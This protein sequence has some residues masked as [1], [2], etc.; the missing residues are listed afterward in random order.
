LPETKQGVGSK[1]PTDIARSQARCRGFLC[2][3]VGWRPPATPAEPP[4]RGPL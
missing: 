2:V 4:V 1:D 3:V